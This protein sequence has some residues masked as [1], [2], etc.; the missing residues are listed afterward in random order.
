MSAEPTITVD[1]SSPVPLWSQVAQQFEQAIVD[2][3]L[4]PGDKLDTEVSLARRLGLSRPTMRQAIQLL[5]DK[6]MVVRKRGVGTQVVHGR[7]RRPL[8]LTSLYDDLSAAGERPRTRILALHREP[9]SPE[10]AHELQ[11][12]PGAPVWLLDRLRYLGDEPLALMRNHL[13]AELVDLEAYDLEADGLYAC[14]R[15][16]GLVMTLAR[17]RISSR[18]ATVQEA[19]LLAETRGAPLLTM[20]RTSFDNGGR[21]VEYGEHAYRP[22]L[23]S[24]ELTLVGR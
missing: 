3:S 6:G 21:T 4:K 20:Q 14:L 8:E 23:Y 10:V 24:F 5:V 12:D 19:A 16:S 22:E 2:G 15:R 7:V 1:R 13:D 18:R 11:V 9:A 17:Q